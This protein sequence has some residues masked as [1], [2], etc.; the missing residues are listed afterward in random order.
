MRACYKDP[1]PHNIKR[2]AAVLEFHM[3]PSVEQ[4]SVLPSGEEHRKNNSS[5][6][7]HQS[8]SLEQWK[9]AESHLQ[10]YE[11]VS[12]ACSVEPYTDG[13]PSL[14]TRKLL[15]RAYIPHRYSSIF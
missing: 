12:R 4:T 7:A 9:C 3:H 10:E 6:H 8:E 13:M 5:T 11:E 1:T 2:T 15:N 14:P